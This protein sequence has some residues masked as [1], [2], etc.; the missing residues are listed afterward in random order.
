MLERLQLLLFIA[1]A[2]L[3]LGC[4]SADESADNVGGLVT[5]NSVAR[6]RVEVNVVSETNS[7]NRRLTD[8]EGNYSAFIAVDPTSGADQATFSISI[9]GEGL[10]AGASCM[11]PSPQAVI[12][13][14][15]GVVT[16][17]RVDFRCFGPDD[18]GGGG[19][20]SGGDGGNGGAG[21]TGGGGTGGAG[22][23][24]GAASPYS[25]CEEPPLGSLECECDPF[26]PSSCS[27]NTDCST[28]FFF[29]TETGAIV[30]IPALDGSEEIPAT[31]CIN[32]GIQSVGE[33]GDCNIVSTVTSRRD[34]CLPGL[35]CD[36]ESELVCVP[37]CVNNDDC[38]DGSC[39]L[40]PLNDSAQGPIGRCS[41]P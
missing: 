1:S 25:Q 5:Y 31:E 22:G 40:F 7:V 30:G 3:V 39:E 34:D 27:G 19:G 15:S 37:L 24:N 23:G 2:S 20:G 41:T 8:S 35:F 9:S 10:P 29:D 21:G 28:T 26:D 11:P 13:N 17:A 14:D 6:P 33:G 38:A 12:V 4:E 36:Q 32:L 16:P 18:G